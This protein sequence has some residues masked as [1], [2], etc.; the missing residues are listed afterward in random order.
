[1][2]LPSWVADHARTKMEPNEEI[3]E[4]QVLK[5]GLL[6]KLAVVQT[7]QR[8][9]VVSRGLFGGHA[10]DVVQLRGAGPTSTSQVPASRPATIKAQAPTTKEPARRPRVASATQ[11]VESKPAKAATVDDLTTLK[12]VGKVRAE[13]LNEAGISSFDALLAADADTLAETLSVSA[14]TVR[15]WQDAARNR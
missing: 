14:E 12:G 1:M 15:G 13:R 5:E 8:N 10:F 4:V 7:S 2:T 3:V 6:N 9:L 11:A